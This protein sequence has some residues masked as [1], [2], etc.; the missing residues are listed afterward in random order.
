MTLKLFRRSKAHGVTRIIVD[1]EDIGV[2][3]SFRWHA[4]KT[5]QRSLG[6]YAI[7]KSPRPDS[8]CLKLHRVIMGDS[9]PYI[10][11]INNDSLDNRRSNLRWATNAENCRNTTLRQNNKS[12]FKGVYWNRP[13]KKWAAQAA[14]VTDKG[15]N[16]LGRK[17]ALGLFMAAE[18]AARAYDGY[19]RQHYGEFACLNFPEAGEL[20]AR[21]P[22]T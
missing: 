9:H 17:L 7:T 22:A 1:D 2:V 14:S 18:D 4:A 6:L 12:G 20:P 16:G 19:A 11:H 10:D 15:S 21:R 13:L 3:L 8:R 5:G